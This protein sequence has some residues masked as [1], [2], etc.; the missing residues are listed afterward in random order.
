[1][2]L[3]SVVVVV[4]VVVDAVVVVERVLSLSSLMARVACQLNCQLRVG[5][6]ACLVHRPA[7]RVVLV[8]NN[9]LGKRVKVRVGLSEQ[10]GYECDGNTV[11]KCVTRSGTYIYICHRYCHSA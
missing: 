2:C 7:L 6:E 4:V 8:R 1:M 9:C 3:G 5:M 11:Y 10:M